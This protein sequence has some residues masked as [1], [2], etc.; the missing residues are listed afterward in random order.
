VVCGRV[1]IGVREKKRAGGGPAVCAIGQVDVIGWSGQRCG[2]RLAAIRGLR[3]A[4][5]VPSQVRPLVDLKARPD[6]PCGDSTTLN[7]RATTSDR[8]ARQAQGLSA[9]RNPGDH[10]CQL[11]STSVSDPF[12]LVAQKI[13]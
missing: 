2:S 6:A 3:P 7:S 1:E 5:A 9:W 8:R 13:S 10:V 4:L 11:T 12:H